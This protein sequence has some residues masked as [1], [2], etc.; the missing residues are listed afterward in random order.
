MNYIS[1]RLSR[2]GGSE[3]LESGV[4]GRLVSF[5]IIAFEVVRI[6][7]NPTIFSARAALWPPRSPEF[8]F[9]P[10]H[11]GNEMRYV[12]EGAGVGALWEVATPMHKLSFPGFVPRP[13]PISSLS[14]TICLHFR[15]LSP[16]FFFFGVCFSFPC[17][18]R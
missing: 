1:P 6:F 7:L 4:K 3:R 14:S 13:Q 11:F 9:Q 18:I 16:F 17:I 12:V 8:G 10:S 5:Y 15:V 2:H